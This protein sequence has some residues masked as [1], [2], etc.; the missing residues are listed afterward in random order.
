MSI[1]ETGISETSPV[2]PNSDLCLLSQT[3]PVPETPVVSDVVVHLVSPKMNGKVAY[4]S[5]RLFGCVYVG[6]I[7]V[8]YRSRQSSSW[9][10]F[11]VGKCGNTRDYF[12]RPI[13]T[14]ITGVIESEIRRVLAEEIE[15]NGGE[16]YRFILSSKN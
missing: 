11:K 8:Y 1:N 15:K 4:A 9:L 6:C 2:L 13:S 16:Q 14:D 5:C 7:S 10:K 3:D 12:F